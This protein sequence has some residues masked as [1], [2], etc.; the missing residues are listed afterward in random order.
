[1]WPR[2]SGSPSGLE[3]RILIFSVHS[4]SV[5]LRFSVASRLKCVLSIAV[6]G[7]YSESSPRPASLSLLVWRSSPNRVL[8]AGPGAFINPLESPDAN[9][10]ERNPNHRPQS[11]PLGR[12]LVA[13]LL[14]ADRFVPLV[15][16]T[17]VNRR[18]GFETLAR[19]WL[20]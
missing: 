17:V 2:C 20:T 14:L 5:S 12:G 8:C 13:P 4:N 18:I 19:K 7:L 9:L 3:N 11:P 15:A 16:R 10:L 1:M 6:M